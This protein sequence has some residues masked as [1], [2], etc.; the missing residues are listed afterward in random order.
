MSQITY[1]DIPPSR[2]LN[3]TSTLPSHSLFSSNR[4]STLSELY[5][6]STEEE[7]G[8]KITLQWRELANTTSKK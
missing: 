6:E 7:G 4:T 2:K 8:K 5:P 3:L 1:V